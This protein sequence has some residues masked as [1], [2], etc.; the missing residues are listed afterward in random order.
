M[1]PQRP[2]PTR[3]GPGRSPRGP[4]HRLRAGAMPW[5]SRLLLV[6]DDLGVDDVV[7]RGLAGTGPGTVTTGAAARRRALGRRSLVQLLGEALAGRHQGVGG[8]ADGLY[9]AAAERGAQVAELVLDRRLLVARDLVALLLE[10]LLG[11]VDER[12]GLVADLG[13][14]AAAPVLLGV[15]LG[16]AGHLLDVVPRQR[17]L[18]GDGHRLLLAR[19]PVLGGHVHDAVGV[20]VEG[21]LDL[22]DAAGRGR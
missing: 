4:R 22:R 11:L 5:G 17:G 20:D 10:Q 19:G 13:L 3:A 8:V 1:R 9:V 14:L 12:V 21:D 7:V 2:H 16:I 15:L 6:V 18:A